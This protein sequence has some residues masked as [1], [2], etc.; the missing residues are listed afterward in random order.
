MNAVLAPAIRLMEHLRYPFKFGLIF[1]LVFLCL[2]GLSAFVVGELKNKI[3]TWENERRGLTYLDALRPPIE[4]IQ[5]HRGMTHSYLHGDQGFHDRILQK[6]DEVEKHLEALQRIDQ[7]EGAALK[8][9]DR[10]QTLQ[11]QWRRIKS[12]SMT[13]ARED[14]FKA[15][16]DLIDGFIELAH[17]VTDS[18]EITLDPRLDGYYLGDT[19]TNILPQLAEDMGQ[20]RALSAGA[21]AAGGLGR[22]DAITLTSLVGRINKLNEDLNRNL[23]TAGAE[24]AEVTA[25]LRD[26]VQKSND[27]VSHFKKMINDRL[28][29][30]E[31]AAI[32][33]KAVFDTATTA[34]G[35][36]YALYGSATRVFDKILNDRIDADRQKML[37]TASVAGLVLL[38][39]AYLF[40]ALYYSII[41]NLKTIGDAT[42]RFADG[43]LTSRVKL[44][45][46]DELSEI[47]AAFNAMNA[48]FEMLIQQINGSTSQLAAAAE[49]LAAISKESAENVDLQRLETD[50]VATAMNEM[51]ATVQEVA[52]NTNAAAGAA[53]QADQEAKNSKRVVGLTSQGIT[54]LAGEIEKA[55]DVI[56]RVDSDSQNIGSVLDVIRGIAEQTNLLAL[57]AAIEAARAG[58]QGR[59]FAVVA[60]EVRT[61]AGRTQQS[62]REIQDMIVTLQGGAREAVQVMEESR[63]H[64][65][66]SVEQARAAAGAI[67][68]I[69]EAVTII[70][71][72]NI[73]IA[74]AAEQQRVTTEDMNRSITRIRDVAEQTAASAEQTT[75]ASDELAR[76]AIQLQNLVGRFTVTGM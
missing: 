47:G 39:V 21:A 33:S 35:A 64:A 43:D 2:L 1:L 13:M 3:N 23:K 72:M 37:S 19:L 52:N 51:T 17:H 63:Q 10:L 55:A 18:S 28:L 7:R 11:Q 49:E 34:I 20:A 71:R 9:A 29:Q 12:E 66:T 40:S 68:V 6:R 15:H 32:D 62:T 65:Q 74:T 56:K 41:G 25:S 27:A 53:E 58:E 4:H 8:T 45:G 57:N 48:Q 38:I 36:T 26:S 16:T 5:Q 42:R 24:N 67:D 14:S 59:G 54:L 75:G 61:L 60:D 46:R 70:N 30:T 76:L 73:Q 22:E 69:T 50:Q 31:A 44:N